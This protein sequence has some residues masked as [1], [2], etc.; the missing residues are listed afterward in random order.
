MDFM[1]FDFIDLKDIMDKITIIKPKKTFS[2]N[3]LKEVWKYKELA[4]L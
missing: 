3:D 1:T 4:Y 2:L